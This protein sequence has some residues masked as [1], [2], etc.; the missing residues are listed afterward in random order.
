M[1][2]WVL[3][4]RIKYEILNS[5][6]GVSHICPEPEV[7]IYMVILD[8][9]YIELSVYDESGDDPPQMA[10]NLYVGSS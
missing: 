2:K 9:R 10:M 1:Y 7:F 4:S 5:Q 8:I 3:W 6:N